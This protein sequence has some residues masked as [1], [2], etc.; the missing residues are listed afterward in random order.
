MKTL[1]IHTNEM[2]LQPFF[3][4]LANQT[5]HNLTSVA[6]LSSVATTHDHKE[7]TMKPQI[8]KKHSDTVDLSSTKN[9]NALHSFGIA[10][11]VLLASM[12]FLARPAQA[13]FEAHCLCRLATNQ[14][15]SLKHLDNYIKDFGVVGDYHALFPQD[16]AH[17]EQCASDCQNAAKPWVDNKADMCHSFAESGGAI[18]CSTTSWALWIGGISAGSRRI[19]SDTRRAVMARPGLP[20][21]RS[22]QRRCTMPHPVAPRGVPPPVTHAALPAP[23]STPSLV[24]SGSRPLP[25]THFQLALL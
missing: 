7:V 18:W 20:F 3:G 22:T 9:S 25:K 2:T 13:Q 6:R 11:L 1:A 16:R 21:R 4:R 8:T 24:R 12:L 14:G 23:S 10:L 17:Q 19:W 15:G 5:T